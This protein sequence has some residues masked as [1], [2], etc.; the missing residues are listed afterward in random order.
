MVWERAFDGDLG[1]MASND[2]RFI[3]F[4][5]IDFVI[6]YI[7]NTQRHCSISSF[8]SSFKFRAK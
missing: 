8:A 3:I 5:C 1:W 7:G 2:P 4:A 6:E